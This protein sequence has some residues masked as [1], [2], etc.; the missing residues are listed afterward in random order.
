MSVSG[1]VQ[2]EFGLYHR[3]AQPALHPALPEPDGGHSAWW[4]EPSMQEERPGAQSGWLPLPCIQER[5]PRLTVLSYSVSPKQPAMGK[6]PD[7]QTRRCQTPRAG[8]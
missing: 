6:A 7:S 4:Q 2:C 3:S 8:L 1:P 5:D